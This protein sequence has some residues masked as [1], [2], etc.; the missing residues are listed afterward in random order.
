MTDQTLFT[1]EH[2]VAGRLVWEADVRIAYQGTGNGFT[3][4]MYDLNTGHWFDAPRD[5]TDQIMAWANAN[6]FTDLREQV[7][8]YNAGRRADAIMDAAE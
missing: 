4:E 5:W 6:R 8:D 7:R 1:Y 3:V 2:F